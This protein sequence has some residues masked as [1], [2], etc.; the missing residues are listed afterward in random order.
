MYNIGLI[1]IGGWMKSGKRIKVS[2]LMS[3]TVTLLCTG[4]TL[5]LWL[6]L[7]KSI[8]PAFLKG[9]LLGGLIMFPL[10]IAFFLYGFKMITCQSCGKEL[11]PIRVPKNFK[12]ATRGGWTCSSCGREVDRKGEIL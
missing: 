12:Q 11:P 6:L 5:L 9:V 3:L 4:G 1:P 10:V 8:S 7:K 2:I